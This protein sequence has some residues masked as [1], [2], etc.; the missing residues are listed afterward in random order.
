MNKNQCLKTY[1]KIDS[2]NEKPRN[3]SETKPLYR[4]EYDERLIKD[5]HYAKFKKN[6]QFT[7]QNPS[8]KAL[9]EK[10]DWSDEDTQELLKNLR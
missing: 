7:Q 6:L 2:L 8:L 5:L 10:E 3:T 4:S 9:L 1:K